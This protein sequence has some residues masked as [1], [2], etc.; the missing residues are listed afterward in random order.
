M[1][2]K[3]Y[4]TEKN[5]TDEEKSIRKQY[6]EYCETVGTYENLTDEQ[7]EKRYKRNYLLQWAS[8]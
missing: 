8:N 5:M 3:K 2:L 6:E 7:L 4:K 1:I